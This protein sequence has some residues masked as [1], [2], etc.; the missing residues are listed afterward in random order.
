MSTDRPPFGETL[1][2]R[3]SL[4]DIAVFAIVPCV[5]VGMFLLPVATRE[6]LAFQYTQP[7]VLPAFASAYVHLTESHLAVNLVG[8]LLIGSLTL[9]MSLLCGYRTRF[10]IA[11]AT[12]LVVF[13]FLL[14]GFGLLFIRQGF[15]LGFSGVLMALYGYLPLALSDF[16]TEKFHLDTQRNVAPL[17]FFGGLG[18]ITV[19]GLWPSLDSMTVLLGTAGLVVVIALIL[20][21]YGLTILDADEGL[22]STLYFAWR[23]SG[24][25]ELFVVGLTVFLS[26]PLAMFPPDV[27]PQRTVVDTYTHLLAYALGFI[28]TYTAALTSEALYDREEQTWL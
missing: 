7:A 18:I 20:V 21:W 5:L 3:V 14:A 17:L 15:G 24:Y 13:P 28:A 10:Y 25:F 6:A 2:R 26:F 9:V 8:Y 4:G 22:R 11:L 19:L 12:Y 27:V 16:V 1:R 23:A